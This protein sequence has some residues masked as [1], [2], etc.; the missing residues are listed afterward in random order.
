VFSE[1]F[2]PSITTTSSHGGKDPDVVAEL[3]AKFLAN[4]LIGGTV[5]CVKEIV[6]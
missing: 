3:T 4:L 5:I 1:I 2:Q 6:P